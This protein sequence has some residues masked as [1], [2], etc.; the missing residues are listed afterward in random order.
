V[1]VGVVDE[2]LGMVEELPH[3]L[4]ATK[5]PMRRDRRCIVP[6]RFLKSQVYRPKNTLVPAAFVGSKSAHH[7]N[8]SRPTAGLNPSICRVR[9][10]LRQEA[11]L[12]L[13]E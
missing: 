6:P 1:L 13:H 12:G 2:L 7:L 10:L 11:R 5:T 9:D 8:L 4:A 3:A